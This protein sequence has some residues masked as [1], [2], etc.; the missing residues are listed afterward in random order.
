[1]TTTRNT[2]L[3]QAG[4]PALLVAACW[5]ALAFYFSTAG[6]VI[7]AFAW[8]APVPVL[9]FAF[10]HAAAQRSGEKVQ[11]GAW[12]RIGAAA[13]LAAF[14]G[15]LA[16]VVLYWG[17]LPAAALLA[18]AA[19]TGAAFAVTVLLTGVIAARFGS[20][21]GI[22]GFPALWVSMEFACARWSP[23]GTAGSVAYTQ[24]DIL[25][26]IQLA[27]WAGLAAITFGLYLVAGCI[28]AVLGDRQAKGIRWRLVIAPALVLLGALLL[29]RMGA[30][31]RFPAPGG[32]WPGW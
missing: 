26:L 28:A 23:H 4:W 30:C 14:G 31:R 18:L 11:A 13:F 5:G 17:I 21:A 10:A 27:S 9:A 29:R 32:W 6:N 25:P 19:V 15:N 16:W 2:V 24:V 8:I 12:T 3:R 20:L 1:M 22:V 7:P